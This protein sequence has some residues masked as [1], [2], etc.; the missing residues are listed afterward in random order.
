[1][2]FADVETPPSPRISDYER[3]A[4][5]VAACPADRPLDTRRPAVRNV[6]RRIAS[7]A[8]E[9]FFTER[10]VQLAKPGGI[11]AVIL[12]ESILASDQLAPLR[13]WLLQE[14]QLLA[15]VGLP[16]KVFTGVGAKN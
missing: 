15:V 13:R 11:I 12:P 14:I 1:M 5:D 7:T 9:V 16:Q 10:F 6:I 3:M 2:L 4:Q 8:I